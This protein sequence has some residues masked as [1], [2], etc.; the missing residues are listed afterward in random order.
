MIRAAE[1]AGYEPILVTNQ[2][3]CEPGSSCRVLPLFEF[4]FW[5]ESSSSWW[6][7][8]AAKLYRAAE[9]W[10]IHFRKRFRYSEFGL[11]WAS[12]REWRKYVAPRGASGSLMVFRS[13]AA[14][15]V[16]VLRAARVICAAVLLPLWILFGIIGWTIISSVRR[17]VRIAVALRRH[18]EVPSLPTLRSYLRSLVPLA[19]E[20]FHLPSLAWSL[21]S[22]KVT[23]LASRPPDP[24]PQS[25]AFGRDAGRM[26]RTL[27]PVAGDIVF[28]PTISEHDLSGLAEYIEH[29]GKGLEATWHFLFRRNIYTGKRTEYAAQD[30]HLDELRTTFERVQRSVL[31][32]RSFFYTD[33]E[34]LTEQYDRL[35]TFRFQTLPIPHTYASTDRI[36]HGGP[37][38][39]TYLG[40]ARTEK[41][42]PL[43]PELVEFLERTY[44]RTRRAGL[45][46]QCNYNIPGGEP[47]TAVALGQLESM[48]G[49]H[50]EFY[51][52]ALTSDEY[53]HLLL[54]ADINLLLYDSSNYYARSS[55]ILVESLA[56]GIPVIV[57]T[58][59]WLSRQFLDRYLD[60]VEELRCRMVVLATAKM[61]ELARRLQANP[62]ADA[63]RR[64]LPRTGQDAQ[65]RACC[66]VPYGA[67]HIVL[68]GELPVDSENA[69]LTICEVG[70]EGAP[71]RAPRQVRLETSG[72]AR[73]AGICMELAANVAQLSI[74]LATSDGTGA[75]WLNALEIEFLRAPAGQRLPAG[76]VGLIYHSAAEIPDL[77]RDLIDHYPHYERTAGEFSKTWREY[78]NADR[79][80]R[81][82]GV[83]AGK[84]FRA[85]GTPARAEGV[86]V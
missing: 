54:T 66:E 37:L 24:G 81:E 67:T 11:A 52:K 29:T 58:G 47:K 44:L 46:I 27:A 79:L 22:R 15:S 68:R 62:P 13:A 77:V 9:S 43:L 5:P 23:S 41:G 71:I 53:R 8:Y 86:A 2:K 61:S 74:S 16:A 83:M 10:S 70:W 57:P 63:P 19:R 1:R 73:R 48:P 14:A 56:V 25:R 30:E 40:D 4:G 7:K 39:L 35:G 76:A 32:D 21:F 51:K 6:W 72:K 26:L 28:F 38:Q 42:F 49:Q 59:C 69:F 75:F 64:G 65:H 80:V 34:E 50:I 18:E 12:R 33:T 78:H 60:H 36:R 3:F 45:A 17:G 20:F 85:G 31:A 84:H 55:G 82:I